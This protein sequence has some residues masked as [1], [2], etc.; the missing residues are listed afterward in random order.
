VNTVSFTLMLGN[1]HFNV[2]LTHWY[3]RLCFQI[4]V[5]RRALE[6]C[7]LT[8]LYKGEISAIAKASNYICK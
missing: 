7:S 2:K 6:L 5:Q 4:R 1:V 8:V 3:F